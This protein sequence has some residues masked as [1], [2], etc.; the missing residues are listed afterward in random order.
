MNLQLDSYSVTPLY[1][2]ARTK[3]SRERER[4]RI[5]EVDEKDGGKN[6]YGGWGW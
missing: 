2:S 6:I 4:G 5:Y 1:R 3:V